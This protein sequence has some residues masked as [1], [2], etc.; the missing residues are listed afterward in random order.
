VTDL[1]TADSFTGFVGQ[2][3]PRLRHAL[4]AAFGTEVGL[5]ATRDALAI[6]WER[7]D[8][9][10]V[11]ANPAGYLYGIGRNKARRRVRRRA[12]FPVPPAAH[13]PYV[14]PALPGAL[15]RLS[16]RQRVA[17]MLLHGYDW[18]HAEVAEL[19]GVSASTVQ[20]HASRG[21][22][23]LRRAMGVGR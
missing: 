15:R 8:Q 4:V 1:K 16:E 14:E 17:V 12:V 5:E 2:V 20:Q 13:E 9:V 10:K 21:M 19:L 3:E 23:K 11:K 6:G 18:T 22:S 7:W